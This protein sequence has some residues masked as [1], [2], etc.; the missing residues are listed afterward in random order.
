MLADDPFE[1]SPPNK[2]EVLAGA[3]DWGVHI[4]Y[5]GV[6]NPAISQ[7]FG[8]NLIVNMFASVARGEQTAEEAAAATHEQVEAIFQEWRDRGLVGGGE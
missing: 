5:P 6:A 3:A 1:S 4:G 2:L 8:E 7:V